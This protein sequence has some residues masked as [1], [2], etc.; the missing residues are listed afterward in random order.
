MQLILK[1]KPRKSEV[2]KEC[3]VVNLF[4]VFY[5][6]S[7]N[8]FVVYVSGSMVATSCIGIYLQCSVIIICA[9]YVI[10]EHGTMFG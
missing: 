9:S 5:R 6:L 3:V 7:T 2:N 8:S 10:V 4:H 1:I